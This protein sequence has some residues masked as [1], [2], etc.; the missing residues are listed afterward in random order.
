MPLSSLCTLH[1]VPYGLALGIGSVGTDNISD[2]SDEH[3]DQKT[4]IGF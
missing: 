2:V 4:M 3:T 1:V